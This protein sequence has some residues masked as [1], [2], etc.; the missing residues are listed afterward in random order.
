MEDSVE[1]T[2][3]VILGGGLFGCALAFHL[4]QARGGS[5]VLIDRA[6]LGQGATGNSAG[7]ITVQGWNRWDTALVRES[8]SHYRSLTETTG[9]G[10]YQET[11]GLRVVRTEAGVR[12]L[13]VV[14]TT[15][16]SAGVEA[17]SLGPSE[18]ESRLP[19]W[20]LDDVRSGLHTPEDAVFDPI[21][22][23]A[24][25]AHQAT[26]GG[27]EVLWG[28]GVPHIDITPGGW[29]VANGHG[30]RFRAAKLVL[31]CGAW[32]KGI[33]G[34]LGHALPVTPFRTQASVLRPHP[35]SDT[36]PTFHDTDL[37][38]Y[39]RQN[40][41]GRL[42]VG[43]GTSAKEVDPDTSPP[44]ADRAF[45]DRVSCQV[46]SLV[47][48]F[49]RLKVERGWAGVCVASPDGLPV[50]GKVPGAD[51]LYVATG[52]NGFGVM[53]ASALAR[54]LA[55]GIVLDEW[56]ALSPA[57]PA[58]F[59]PGT[60]ASDPA[61]EFSI[62]DDGSVAA[63]NGDMGSWHPPDP[64]PVP[65][66]PIGYV[67]VRSEEEISGLVLPSLSNWFDPFLPTFMRDS[68][69]CGGEAFLARDAEGVVLGIFL[70]NPRERTAS[71]F[72]RVRSVA[73]HFTGTTRSAE[74][75]A[76]QPWVRAAH[77]LDI[78][79]AEVGDI[80]ASLPIRNLV[81]VAD[82]ADMPR[83]GALIE[84]VHGPF[85]DSWLRSLPRPDEMC[86]IAEV[87]GRVVGTSW[88][89]IV[90]RYA[91]GHS[92]AVHPR[93]RKIGIGTDLLHARMLWLRSQGV[94]RLVSEIPVGNVASRTAAE[95]AG[96]AA[97]GR[98]F[99]FPTT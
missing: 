18:V 42:L 26:K 31:A 64:G 19:G 68:L 12:W 63:E 69:R 92:L 9:Q 30:R 89:T 43:N 85:A 22:I 56:G 35:L 72:T 87:E 66:S 39:I 44:A 7:I 93:Y 78:M 53:R 60:V 2:D 75:Y 55:L 83:V 41:D 11:G 67:P 84:A 29:E 47:P 81:R 82:T 79:L 99:A 46:L 28:R 49:R 45:I 70:T 10:N 33:L 98:M 51:R 38:I 25:F 36:F 65:S 62:R 80:P 13:E 58:R 94:E 16:Q 59:P 71:L 91:R 15:L 3:V 61:P 37:D 23:A 57:D 17:I 73:M 90:N 6:P 50:V 14:R 97:V 24:Q 34:A 4:T 76:E 86:F 54:R 52:F 20:E 27:A 1:Q 88:V 32:T 96:M 8:A 40:P 21:A 74:V 5:V 77:P 95:H 48:A